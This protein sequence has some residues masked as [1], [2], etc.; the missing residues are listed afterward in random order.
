MAADQRLCSDGCP[1]ESVEMKEGDEQPIERA[2]VK[3]WGENE[4]VRGILENK[5][6]PLAMTG[7]SKMKPANIIRPQLRQSRPSTYRWG[8]GAVAVKCKDIDNNDL[9]QEMTEYCRVH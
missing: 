1:D 8:F 6:N 5:G 4:V 2:A 3:M 9:F 7:M